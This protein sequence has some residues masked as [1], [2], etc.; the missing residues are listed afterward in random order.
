MVQQGLAKLSVAVLAFVF[1]GPLA[2]RAADLTEDPGRYQAAPP[3]YAGPYEPAEEPRVYAPPPAMYER[4]G[5]NVE[6]CRVISRV[7]IDPYGR[8][9]LRPIRVCGQPAA[10][11]APRWVAGPP[12]YGYGPVGYGYGPV[13]YGY[14]PRAYGY[15]PRAYGYGPLPTPYAAGPG[16]Q[17][18]DE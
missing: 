9:V 15:G 18:D 14:G 8:R 7:R 2:A 1:A 16:P 6:R 3:P 17:L 13:R 11:R 4:Y 10:Y 5:A 12:P